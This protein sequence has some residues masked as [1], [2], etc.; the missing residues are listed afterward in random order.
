MSVQ[1]SY[2]LSLTTAIEGAPA[3][4]EPIEAD[5]LYNGEASASIPFGKG[6]KLGA[7]D[8]ECI[9]PAAEGD[10]IWGVTLHANQY[11]K[12]T[13]SPQLDSTGVV[14]G[15]VLNVARKGKCWVRVPTGCTKGERAWCRAVAGGGETLGAFENADDG[16]DMID[17]KGQAAFGSSAAANG[18]AVLEFDFSNYPA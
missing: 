3:T 2:G 18:L 7:Q 14:V 6:V 15:E 17:L 12:G 11:T 5:A 1:T 13:S 9:L 4:A 10:A 16:T 8:N